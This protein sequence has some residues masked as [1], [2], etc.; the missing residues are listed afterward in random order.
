MVFVD[1]GANLHAHPANGTGEPP[2]GCV[3]VLR[4]RPCWNPENALGRPRANC[5]G[6]FVVTRYVRNTRIWRLRSVSGDA[7]RGCAD[8]SAS[9]PPHSRTGGVLDC[10]PGNENL[11]EAEGPERKSARS[12]PSAP[13][14]CLGL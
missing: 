3:V 11:A 7:T 13:A 5:T 14:D 1:V 9:S 12:Q 8:T 10:G 2:V 6:R 4:D